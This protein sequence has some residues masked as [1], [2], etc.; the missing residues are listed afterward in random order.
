MQRL[1]SR[2]TFW[3]KFLF[4]LIWIGGFATGTISLFVLNV[5]PE[6]WLFLVATVIGA[7]FLL[8]V[9][10][11]LKVVWMGD[12]VLRVSNYFRSELIPLA[13]VESVHDSSWLSIRRITLQFTRT[14][15]FGHSILFMPAESWFGLG[16]THPIAIRLRNEVAIARSGS[17]FSAC[18]GE[19]EEGG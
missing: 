14:T 7:T 19:V 2:L 13:D 6:R 4:P 10:A 12:G 9:C 15:S 8:C 5:G 16:G 11:P 1:S 17:S 18:D 3:L